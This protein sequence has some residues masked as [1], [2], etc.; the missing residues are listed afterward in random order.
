MKIGILGSGCSAIY[1]AL[2][3]KEKDPNIDLTLF[4][5]NKVPGKKFLITGNGRCNL[6]NNKVT[7]YSYNNEDINKLI[8]E[9]FI[10]YEKEFFTKIGVE[11]REIGDLVYPYSLSATSLQTYLVNYLLKKGTKFIN[12]INIY[13]YLVNDNDK[14]N[15]KVITDHGDYY[16]D[17]LVIATGG[18]SKISNN[19][20]D[21]LEIYSK[22]GYQITPL[23]SGLAPLKTKEP[24]KSIENNRVK[25]IISLIIDNKEIYQEEGEVLFKKDG[26]SGIAIFN[27]E[28]LIKRL[29]KDNPLSTYNISIDLFPN[30]S[31]EELTSKLKKYNELS[32]LDGVFTDSINRYILNRAGININNNKYNDN[33]IGKVAKIIKQLTFTYLDSY[34]FSDSQVTIGGINI[35][36]LDN[37]FK[38]KIEKNIFF[39]GEVVDVDGLC[40]GYN[41]MYSFFSAKKASEVL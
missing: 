24:T 29:R 27:I 32:F 36:N 9:D 6:L 13:D 2:L 1:L 23:E 26:L 19:Q 28:S 33:E 16:F 14:N 38:S 37:N 17:K 34:S 18:L 20:N 21:L 22:H 12:S 31:L 30:L 35:H 25:G 40:G 3:L 8:D 7:K 41:L 11:L 39:I 10:Q 5:M 4:D 15:I